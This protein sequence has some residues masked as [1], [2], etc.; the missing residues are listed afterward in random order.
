MGGGI[1][2]THDH[3]SAWL[4][5]G[6]LP[7]IGPGLHVAPTDRSAIG[8]PEAIA[9]LDLISPSIGCIRRAV[10]HPAG[11]RATGLEQVTTSSE[12]N[13]SGQLKKKRKRMKR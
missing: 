11:M 1:G 6:L 4:W 7:Q 9:D 2:G 12:G 8:R 13:N 5:Q 3:R 10:D